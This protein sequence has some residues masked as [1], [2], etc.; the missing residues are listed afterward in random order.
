MDIEYLK[1]IFN[2]VYIIEPKKCEDRINIWFTDSLKEQIRVKSNVT[3]YLNEINTL[4]EFNL[5]G[6]NIWNSKID[7]EVILTEKFLIL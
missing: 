1:T 4:N 5:K 2:E 6:G 7:K 3:N